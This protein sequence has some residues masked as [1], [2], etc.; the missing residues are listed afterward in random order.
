VPDASGSVIGTSPACLPL[1]GEDLY[2]TRIWHRWMR[3]YGVKTVL[4]GDWNAG[5]LREVIYVY[6]PFAG[7]H[8]KPV[9]D[10]PLL[11]WAITREVDGIL[12]LD[13]VT[14]EEQVH[15]TVEDAFTAIRKQIGDEQA[16]FVDNIPESLSRPWVTG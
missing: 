14:G 3:L 16:A 2:A 11:R 6:P 15:A 9:T 7:L 4:E 8:S 1:T 5:R 12:F 10:R 13:N